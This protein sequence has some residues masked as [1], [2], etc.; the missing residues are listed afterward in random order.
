[1]LIILCIVL[2]LLLIKYIFKIKE[3]LNV[4]ID[5]EKPKGLICYYG[6]SFREGGSG[7]VT[8][9]TTN[10]L[11]SQ[12][13]ATQSHIKL[14]NFL[15]KKKYNVDT[16]ITTYH[17]KHEEELNKWYNPYDII[18]NTINKNKDSTSGRDKLISTSINNIKNLTT[19][20]YD[21]ILFIRIDLFLKPD[22]F[23]KLDIK[24]NKINFLAH[25]FY[26]GHCGFT[27][28]RDPEVVDMIL[29]VPKN[30]FYILDDKFKL[31]HKAWSYYKKTYKLTYDDLGFMSSLRFDSNTYLDYNP[32]YIISG[33]P[34]NKISHND[35]ET[36]SFVYGKVG[37]KRGKDC[38]F[39]TKKIK[40]EYLINPSE[41]YYNSHKKFYIEN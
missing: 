9:D 36:D 38:P 19:N 13:Y 24:S 12:Y 37:N 34:A 32:F 30:Y 31:N 10:G 21:F 2:L 15:K 25:N 23:N 39:Y 16:I 41:H 1:M 6:G 11:N 40:D 35:E 28:N 3:G 8:Q 18:Y 29:F 26:K 14:T 27:E 22:F 5:L 33:R 17:S 7:S 4:E 20:D